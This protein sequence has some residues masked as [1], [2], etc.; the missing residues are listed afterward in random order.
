MYYS[1]FIRAV[2]TAHYGSPVVEQST[3]LGESIVITECGK[4]FVNQTEIV[5]LECAEEARKYIKQVKL[6]EELIKE[7]YEDIPDIKIANLIQ[8]HHNI[9]VTDTLIE[10]YKE[11]A[12]SKLFSVD[13]VIQEMRAFNSIT[14]EL[15]GKIDYHLDDGSIV[16]IDED[17]NISINNLLVNNNEIVQYMRES[18]Q[19]FMHII[20]ELN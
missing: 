6:E 10:S 17:T 2:N 15:E 5:G 1:Q 12:S 18:K 8:E 11:L 16:A 7:I 4:V 14:N 13:P 20:R 9:K 3:Y 19:N